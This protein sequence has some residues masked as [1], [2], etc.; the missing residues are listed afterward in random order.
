MTKP[1]LDRFIADLKSNEALRADAR[2]ALADQSHAP[3]VDRVVAFA[4]RKG[5]AFTADEAQEHVKATAS[6]VG[7]KLTDVEL[8]GVSAGASDDVSRLIFDPLTGGISTGGNF[9][10][11]TGIVAPT[12]VPPAWKPEQA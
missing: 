10:D 12:W 4:A 5:Y 11:D 2:K 9:M 8:D 6:D 3:P 1:E 7:K